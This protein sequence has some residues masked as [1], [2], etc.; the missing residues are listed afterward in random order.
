L[1]LYGIKL[2]KIIKKREYKMA[3]LTAQGKYNMAILKKIKEYPDYKNH[4]P[5]IT[6]GIDVFNGYLDYY[7]AYD[8]LLMADVLFIQTIMPLPGNMGNHDYMTIIINPNKIVSITFDTKYYDFDPTSLDLV[9]NSGLDIDIL[10]R[11]IMRICKYGSLYWGYPFKN[12]GLRI[13]DSLYIS[14]INELSCKNDNLFTI[15]S[16]IFIPSS[17]KPINNGNMASGYENI[18]IFYIPTRNL[19]VIGA[20]LGIYPNEL[21]EFFTN[22]LHERKLFL[23]PMF[24][25][26]AKQRINRLIPP[27]TKGQIVFSEAAQKSFISEIDDNVDDPSKDTTSWKEIDFDH[28]YKAVDPIEGIPDPVNDLLS[29]FNKS[30]DLSPLT[31]D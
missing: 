11:T 25:M 10:F 13:D 24:W 12:F 30:Y 28:P 17:N 9:Q 31:Q 27:Y 26:T 23:R 19:N 14:G 6:S 20:Q 16:D 8:D 18:S 5:I 2:D 21:L 7:F 15:K 1:V 4:L 22:L 29:L 3:V